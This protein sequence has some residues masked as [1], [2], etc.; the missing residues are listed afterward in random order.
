MALAMFKSVYSTVYE[1]FELNKFSSAITF[2]QFFSWIEDL[3]S[4]AQSNRIINITIMINRNR[5]TR[6]MIRKDIFSHVYGYCDTSL[7]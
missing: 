4:L 3:M 5:N 2:K 1:R 7:N 6:K